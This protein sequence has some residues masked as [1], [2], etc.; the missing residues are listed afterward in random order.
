MLFIFIYDK[1]IKSKLEISIFILLLFFYI[2]GKLSYILIGGPLY[3]YF[4]LKEI[5]NFKFILLI[6]LACFGFT[7]FPVLLIK[8]Y[9]FGNP[10]APFFDS[11]FNNGRLSMESYALSLRSSEGWLLN[12]SNYLIYLKP[13]IPTSLGSMSNS[14]GIIF[15]L[16][17]LNF[18]L[19]KKLKFFPILIIIIVALTG[20]L[21]PRY[22]F[23]A[24]LI[25]A[26]FYEIKK[27]K[28]VPLI[29]YFQ[30]FIILILSI[31]FVYV[32]YVQENVLTD[33][34]SFMSRFSY[35]YYNSLQY[36]TLKLDKNI[37][38]VSQDRDTIFFKI[39]YFQTDI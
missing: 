14:L 36:N 35:S 31:S 29:A 6:S 1:R 16:F 32:S 19:L 21:L 39:T 25:L 7:I 5:K 26:Y 2:S 10:F 4:F 30:S 33:K 34:T 8:Y 22:Y 13:F 38:V 15:L 28:I 23:E 11:I 3:I 24:F 20:Q 27:Y 12:P 37:Y 18:T 9:Y 17:L